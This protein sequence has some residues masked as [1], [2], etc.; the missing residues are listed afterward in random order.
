MHMPGGQIS[1][2]LS[3]ARQDTKWARKLDMYLSVMKRQG[4]ISIHDKGEIV[5][6]KK[7]NE[8]IA[9]Y[10][11]QASLILL[12]ISPDFLASEDT[13]TFEMQRA[14]QR[15]EAGEA[16]VIPLIVRPSDWQST[17]FAHLSPLPT[18]ARAISIWSNQDEAF[19][20]VMTGLR[21]S[22][23]DL[24]MFSTKT[25]QALRT[26]IWNVPYP[27][28]PFFI[29]RDDILKQLHTQLHNGQPLALSQSPRAISGLGGIG[30][31]HIATEYA[32]RYA[33]DY[34]VVL[35]AH[36][37][38]L[39]TLISSFLSIATLLK[40]PQRD[41]KEQD[42][43]LSDV[44]VWL[45]THQKWLLILDNADE[46]DLLSP[47]LPPSPGGHILLTTRAPGMQ[48]L[49]LTVEVH[50]FSAEQ[51]ALFLLQRAGLLLPKAALDQALEEDRIM[52]ILISQ[53]LGGLP[54]ALEQAGAY[55]IATGM[56]VQEYHELYQTHRKFLLARHEP[57]VNDHPEAVA[58]T[59]SLSFKR[60]QQKNP[61][62]ADL[63][64]LCAYL[65][66]DAIAEEILT[67]NPSVLGP[68]LASIGTDVFQRHQAIEALRT[69]SLIQRD[70][71]EKILS[72]HRLVQAVLC[73]EQ[74][75]AEQKL[76]AER[77]VLAINAAFPFPEPATWPQC[78]RLLLQAL[79]AAQLI[80]RY[81]LIHWEVGC[82][83]IVS[84]AY[85]Q[86]LGRYKDAEPL[87]LQALS[88]WEQIL[89]P[90]H[91][92][93]ASPLHNL[94]DLY[95]DQGKYAQAEP[96]A[97]RALRIR[98]QHLGTE[99]LN[100]ANLVN[101]LANIYAGQGKYVQAEPLFLR[102]LRI[103]EQNFGPE[104]PQVASA[105]HNLATLSKDQGKYVQAEPLFLQALYIWEQNFGPEH[106]QVAYSLHNLADLYAK[107]GKYEQAESLFLQA[108]SIWEQSLGLEH[109]RL[110]F[111]LNGLAN[112]YTEQG[113]YEQAERL[114]LRALHI[115]EQ[116]L[117][118]EHLT[119]AATLE[120]L[121][122]IYTKAW[123]KWSENHVTHE[124][125]D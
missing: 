101:G 91:P 70:P 16:R 69:Y 25:S 52:A 23:E 87:F 2:F 80:Q 7:R 125:D 34:D 49:A 19:L 51:G 4:L 123:F 31:T 45:Q 92:N 65:A 38:S 35:W 68:V 99:H 67:A 110:V 10:L 102:A 109:P 37:E 22:I 28:N 98:E 96:I 75:E 56:S 60:I 79:A 40:L 12:L 77:A 103:W 94:A 107:Q 63:L 6:G 76:W 74:D 47:F 3:Y 39:E 124:R 73:D 83:L 46:P 44:K 13:Y 41:K 89:G 54:L 30:K 114:L 95:K 86:D 17:P 50:A 84:A 85:L 115:Y 88:L 82:L 57:L 29:G 71:R 81:H 113:R 122:F 59:W 112:L 90:D 55:I 66:P 111:P 61:A 100:V 93:V 42:F 78:G 26:A 11:D 64:R 15:H 108:L 1:V 116:S 118:R 33:Q 14:L 27:R 18:N 120:R 48:R 53:E 8:T 32:Y 117:G 58:T 62:A 9:H 21:L 119:V 43:I 104:H 5:A 106:P 24:S 36:A 97:L 20:N 121:A 72:V 105:L